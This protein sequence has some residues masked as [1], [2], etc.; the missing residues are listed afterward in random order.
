VVVIGGG[1]VG[2]ETALF[3]AERGTLSGE[4][5]KFFLVNKAEDP[6]LIYELATRGTKE[7][8]LIEMIG[9]IGRDIGKS[10]RWTMVQEMQRHRIEIRTQTKAL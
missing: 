7:V 9:E 6:D 3:L 10:T 2:V 1:A 5:V 4:T 8:I